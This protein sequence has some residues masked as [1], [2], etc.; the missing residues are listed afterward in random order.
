V[1]LVVCGLWRSDRLQSEVVSIPYPKLMW[2]T[3]LV[4]SVFALVWP[5]LKVAYMSPSE[6]LSRM[7]VFYLLFSAL[8]LTGILT[9]IV[10]NL[11]YTLRANEESSEQLNAMADRIEKNTKT[12]LARALKLMDKL[13]E[14]EQVH[15]EFRKLAAKPWDPGTNILNWKLFQAAR[16]DS[17]PYFDN[18]FWTDSDGNQAYKA[19]VRSKATP[20]TSIQKE[21]YF[22]DLRN[23]G[24][25]TVRHGD[26]NFRF[27]ST[28]SP[29]TGEFFVILAKNYQTNWH[30][31]PEPIRK[32]LTTQ[33]LVTQFLSLY[34]PV[35]P[36][37]FGYTVVSHEGK[38][39]FHSTSARNK[40]EDFFKECRQ[41]PVLT[42]LVTNGGRDELEADYMGKQQQMVVRPMPD[43]GEPGP[44]LIVFRDSNYF[45]T[46]NVASL[47]VFTLLICIFSVPFLL[48]LGAYVFRATNYPLAGVSPSEGQA[49]R[50]IDMLISNGCL[51]IAFAIGFAAMTMNKLFVA[52][53]AVTAVALIF[54]FVLPTRFG[55]KWIPAGKLAVLVTLL[56]IAPAPL[57]LL[58]AAA[59]VVVSLPPVS[60][61]LQ[62]F[63]VRSIKLQY[64]Y[65]AVMFSLLTVVVVLPCFGLFKISYNTV[66]RLALEN[67]QLARLDQLTHRA[68]RA[69]EHFADLDPDAM[70]RGDEQVRKRVLEY[71][72]VRVSEPLD[73]YDDAVFFPHNIEAPETITL[74]KKATSEKDKREANWLE[75]PIAKAAAWFPSNRLGA[76]LRER[77]LADKR[78]KDS[79]DESHPGPKWKSA[80]FGVDDE[81]LWLEGSSVPGGELLGVYP[82]WQLPW[83]AA[84]VM[85]MLAFLLAGWLYYVIR[86]VFLTDLSEVPQLPEWIPCQ[87]GGRNLLIIGFP[88]SGKSTRASKLPDADFLDLGQVVLQAN[89]TLPEFPHSTVV[90]DHFEFDIDNPNTCFE[91]LKLLEEVLYVR[92][93]AVIL[94]SAVDPMFY[95]AQGSPEIV[96]PTTGMHDP[97][98]QVLD[99][100]AAALS[101]FEKLKMKDVE[102]DDVRRALAGQGSKC[103]KE[104][105]ELVVAE[106]PYTEALRRIGLDLLRVHCD[107]RCIST[108]QLMEELLDRAD[109]YYRILWST[110]TKQERLVL[111][112]LAQDGWPNP[113]NDCAIQQLA[114]RRF[115]IRRRG[116]RIMNE[117]FRRFVR[118]AQYPAEIAK[119][120]DEEQHSVWSAMKLGLSTA[121]LMFGAW[122]LYAQQEVFQLGIGYVAA[123]GTAAVAILNLTRGLFGSKTGGS[124]GLET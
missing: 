116:F 12:E 30:D 46:I 58:T 87:S 83:L 102:V 94:L 93:K 34:D 54:G 44:A 42:S 35:V 64:L 51:T 76:E 98:G 112:Q 47:L 80:K 75:L 36:A 32:K 123:L 72:E 101:M 25:H 84:V 26:S 57:G 50:Y 55:E 69:K 20:Q 122:L 33:V 78:H 71:A 6:R 117:S 29:N 17:Y 114:R 103:R 27:D 31:I 97:P 121:L 90:I 73:R 45:S 59:Y 8:F 60:R 77:A 106:C 22:Q 61:A 119:W 2:G 15:A 1:K 124:P 100:W 85:V 110:C 81:I 13:G 120:E 70:K 49:S 95:L 48:G 56:A 62:Q 105:V 52:M 40:V 107:D 37:G 28:Y 89:W 104:L 118:T 9:V 74:L 96:T 66:N 14:D 91:K 115:I 88:K 92:K 65:T 111:F 39:Q 63:A 109:S 3:I 5:L 38:V 53:L 79:G 21:E 68:E 43:L 113:K 24:R 67:A 86:K 99:R 23:D 82:I 41:D 108:G 11:A 16:I 4:L 19:T 7:R 10:L 18:I